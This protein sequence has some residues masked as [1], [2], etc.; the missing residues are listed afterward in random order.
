MTNSYNLNTNLIFSQG[1]AQC[2]SDNTCKP[3]QM[4]S[5]AIRKG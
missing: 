1:L 5:Q 4:L 3:G 2:L